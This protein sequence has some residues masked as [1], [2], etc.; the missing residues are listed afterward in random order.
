M[1]R[2]RDWRHWRLRDHLLV[3]GPA[4]V[5]TAVAFAVAIAFVEPAPPRQIVLATGRPD[6]AYHQFGLRY[7][8]ELARHGIRVELRPTSGSL[9][10]LRLLADGTSG[11]SVAFVQGGVRAAAPAADLV[12]LGSLYFEP[13]WLFAR[14]DTRGGDVRILRGRRIAVGPEGSGTRALVDVLL[15]ANGLGTDTAT[16]LPLTGLDAVRSLRAGEVDAVAL[17]AG[18]DSPAV[19]EAAAMPD[20]EL[21][22]FPRA[23]A[24]ARRFPFLSRLTLP[25]GALNLERNLPPREVQLVAASAG[26]VVRADFHPALSDLLLMTAVDVHGRAGMFESARQFP[27]PDFTDYPLGDEALRFYR[28]GPPFL[29]RYLPFWAATLLDRLKIML[30]PLAALLI[31]LFKVVP[32]TYR[33]RTRRKIYRWYGQVQDADVALCEPRSVEELDRLLVQLDHV[34]HQV[35]LI[36]IPPAHSE[37]H[38]QLRA[39]IDL[40]RAK[41]LAARAAQ[42]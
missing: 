17:V 24:Y 7:Q 15:R 36:P 41:I 26:L 14:G 4:L 40:V 2:A 39:H 9:E 34:E 20:A 35:R 11:V 28:N 32:P 31:P 27:S 3:F 42:R 18:P 23:E 10:N 25:E 13:L 5:L 37:T 30:L 6:G 16:L 22:S 19:R 38:F 21:L 33:W 8:A 1:L 12:A 29:A